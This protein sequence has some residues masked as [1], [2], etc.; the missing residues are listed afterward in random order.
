MPIQLVQALVPTANPENMQTRK[1]SWTA[2]GVFEVDTS[3]EWRVL[4]A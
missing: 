1:A 3:K 4:P 2:L